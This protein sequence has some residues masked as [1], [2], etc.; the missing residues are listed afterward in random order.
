M[1]WSYWCLNSPGSYNLCCCVCIWEVLYVYPT[2]LFVL[3]LYFER[4]IPG[5]DIVAT[6]WRSKQTLSHPHC[7]VHHT[8]CSFFFQHWMRLLRISAL[9]TAF[10]LSFQVTFFKDG[11]LVYSHHYQFPLQLFRC[12]LGIGIFWEI[13]Y[14][15]TIHYNALGQQKIRNYKHYVHWH[16]LC[17]K[18]I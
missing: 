7:V 14:L 5:I 1:L 6:I 2:F 13:E 10:I 12:S 16:S 11:I 4:D 9:D 8:S 18:W 15:L 17:V 3:Y